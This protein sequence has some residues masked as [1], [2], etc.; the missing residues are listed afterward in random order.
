MRKKAVIVAGDLVRAALLLTVPVA[1]MCD[2]LTMLQLCIGGA[3]VGVVTVFFDVA[4]QS[5]LPEIVMSEQLGDG[6][7]KLQA[8]QQTAWVAGPSLA[9]GL[10][11]VIGGPLTIGVTMP[12]L[13]VGWS[14]LSWA[15]VVYNVAQVSFRQRL[16]PKPLLGR[17][18]ASIRFLVWG[19]MPIGAFLGG[20]IAHAIGIVPTLW[21][22]A[23]A[24]VLSSLPVLISPLITMRTLPNE[25]SAL[26]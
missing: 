4:N 17:M 6:N 11:G 26:D 10:V 7:R 16:C 12:T 24:G 25:L 18:N 19:P 5:F 15:V 22:F 23:S 9:S 21:L 3:C 20:T 2:L 1:W 13:L 8:S 14:L